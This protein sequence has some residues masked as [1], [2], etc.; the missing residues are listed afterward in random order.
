MSTR[1]A[2]VCVRS[3]APDKLRRRTFASDAWTRRYDSESMSKSNATVVGKTPLDQLKGMSAADFAQPLLANLDEASRNVQFHNFLTFVPGDSTGS[4]DPSLRDFAKAVLDANV[5]NLKKGRLQRELPY[6][7]AFAMNFVL[8]GVGLAA[9]G[10]AILRGLSNDPITT[11]TFGGVTI[12][13]VITTFLVNPISSLQ[14]SNL[15]NTA[16]VSII[17]SYWTRLLYLDNPTTIDA[18]LKKVTEETVAELESLRAT[19]LNK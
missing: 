14:K 1:C 12:A 13:T 10:I 6:W 16:L 18:D 3:A 19:Y 15:L 5:G 11:A 2:R 9:F 4:L 17:N 8:F 7:T